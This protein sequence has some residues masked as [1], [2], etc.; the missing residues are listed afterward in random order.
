MSIKNKLK[1]QAAVVLTSEG[2]HVARQRIAEVRRRLSGNPHTVQYFHDVADPYC[3]LSLQLLLELQNKFDVQIEPH[4]ISRPASDIQ[5][6]P[7][8]YWQKLQHTSERR[9]TLAGYRIADLV[10]A[11]ADD[12]MAQREFI[13]R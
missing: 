6:L 5:P 9:I 12:I 4:L 3:H 1:T 7:T 2:L 11:A 10:I 13:G 8:E